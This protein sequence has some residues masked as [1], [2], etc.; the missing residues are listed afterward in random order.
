VGVRRRD[1]IRQ[2]LV[3]TTMITITGGALGVL[4]GVALRCVSRARSR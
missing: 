1:I 3:E 2:F 4:V